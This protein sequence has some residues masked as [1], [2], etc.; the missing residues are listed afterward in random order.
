MRLAGAKAPRQRLRKDLVTLWLEQKEPG[1]GRRV[2]RIVWGQTMLA[3]EELWLLLLVGMTPGRG[4]SRGGVGFDFDPERITPAPGSWVGK[5]AR[6]R[7]EAG[8]LVR[9]LL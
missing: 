8:R 2:L 7:A 5:T 4:L 9:R 1:R 6:A 3:L